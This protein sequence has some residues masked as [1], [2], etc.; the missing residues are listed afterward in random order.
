MKV[1]KSLG[2]GV[3]LAGKAS[4]TPILHSAIG[5]SLE[6]TSGRTI[7]DSSTENPW[8]ALLALRT[9]QVQNINPLPAQNLLFHP[10]PSLSVDTGLP[11]TQTSNQ[12]TLT[13]PHPTPSASTCSVWCMEQLSAPR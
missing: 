8:M 9:Q 11:A 12:V 13:S 6:V 10:H 1:S 4:D 5:A 7:P 2:K 3:I